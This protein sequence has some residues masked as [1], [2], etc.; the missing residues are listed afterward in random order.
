MADIT[1]YI[2]QIGEA[3]YGEEVRGAIMNSITEINNEVNKLAFTATLEAEDWAEDENGYITQIIEN[4]RILDTSTILISMHTDP[5]GINLTVA[6]DYANIYH[7]EIVEGGIKFYI[8]SEAAEDIPINYLLLSSQSGKVFF[9]GS[10]V[11]SSGGGALVLRGITIAQNPTKTLYKK[12]ETLSTIGMVVRARYSNGSVADVT[13]QCTISDS[14]AQNTAGQQ[15]I[16]VSYTEGGITSRAVYYITVYELSSIAVTTQPTKRIYRRGETLNTDGMVV[17]ATYTNGNTANVTS[18]IS[19]ETDTAPNTAG[20][21][22]ITVSYTEDDISKTTTYPITVYELSSIAITTQPTK[23]N[24][25]KGVSIST[26]G[27]VVTATYSNGTTAVVTGS[28]TLSTSTTQSTAGN[29]GIVVSYTEDGITKT[30]T[31]TITVY[32]LS[33]IAITTQPTVKTYYSGATIS[34]AG[35]VVTATY[36]DN[37][38]ENVTNNATISPATAPASVTSTSVTV[39]YTEDSVTKTTSYNVTIYEFDATLTVSTIAGASIEVVGTN[40]EKT[41]S[42]TSDNSGD[43]T[44]T[45]HNSDTYQISAI[46]NEMIGEDSIVINSQTQ[47]YTKQVTLHPTY[48]AILIGYLPSTSHPNRVVWKTDDGITFS[49]IGGFDNL[50][51]NPSQ[52]YYID[53]KLLFPVKNNSSPYSARYLLSED[54]GSTWNDYTIRS[55]SSSSANGG[56]AKYYY[57][58]DIKKANGYIYLSGYEEYTVNIN[59]GGTRTTSYHNYLWRLNDITNISS[60]VEFSVHIISNNSS[61]SDDGLLRATATDG[62]KFRALTDKNVGWN[63]NYTSLES[64]GMANAKSNTIIYENGIWLLVTDKGVAY[65]SD[66]DSWTVVNLPISMNLSVPAYTYKPSS[67]QLRFYDGIFYLADDYGKLIKSSDG[68]NWLLVSDSE[69]S[70]SAGEY[71]VYTAIGNSKRF[72]VRRDSNS[73]IIYSFVDEGDGYSEPM[74]SNLLQSIIYP[75]EYYMF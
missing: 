70:P 52:F 58:N 62:T 51:T 32:E 56:S 29:Q 44:F 64:L 69:L 23:L 41:F 36:T 5:T 47:S 50:L 2:E 48:K 46:K 54:G 37:H 9:A 75:L 21:H 27:M 17:T 33:S 72:A 16:T 26:S 20:S 53:G 1:E 30:T 57:I 3:V 67:T 10:G 59:S 35:M 18:E 45:I 28:C 13:A 31:L 7:A 39:S 65:S 63:G 25:R 68:I 6:A 73:N 14:E 19:I 60:L 43:C 71:Y 49:E 61:G 66:G 40:T 4:E 74:E 8:L 22:N 12:G 42:G 38:T 55:G 15:T 24:Y 11:N 34:K